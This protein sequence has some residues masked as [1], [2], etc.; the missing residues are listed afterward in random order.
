[1]LRIG[2]WSVRRAP[3]GPDAGLLYVN[4]ETGRAQ[5]DPPEEVLQE[6]GMDEGEE[7]ELEAPS[8]GREDAAS[9]SRSASRSGSRC[10]SRPGTAT[11]GSG[12]GSRPGSQGSTAPAEPPKFRRILLGN[13]YDMPLAMARDIHAALLEDVSMFDLVQQRFSDAEKDGSLM[14]LDG[15]PEELESV[16]LALAP[17]RVSGVIGTE[18]GMQILLRVC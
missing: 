14:D 4:V 15:L 5:K 6:L 16:A 9:G 3:G 13:G 1:M 17:G 11:R 18:A 12:A 10:G 2:A 7:Q 8:S